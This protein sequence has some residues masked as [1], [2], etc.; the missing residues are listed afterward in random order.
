VQIKR[1][2]YCVVGD[3]S[4]QKNHQSPITNSTIPFCVYS[5]IVGIISALVK[6]QLE[7]QESCF[8]VAEGVLRRSSAGD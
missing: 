3:F 4:P 7:E 8:G 5:S 1:I 2:G 6:E